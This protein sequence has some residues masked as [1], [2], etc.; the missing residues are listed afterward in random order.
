M[1]HTAYPD[2]RLFCLF[3]VMMPTVKISDI[4]FQLPLYCD[5]SLVIFN[6]LSQALVHIQ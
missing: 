2:S 1:A 3:Y 4:H 5:V 6:P